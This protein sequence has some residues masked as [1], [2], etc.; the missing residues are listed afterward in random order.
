[1]SCKGPLASLGTSTPKLSF[2]RLVHS[3]QQQQKQ[4]QQQQQQQQQQ[5]ETNQHLL[6]GRTKR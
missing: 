4:K 2:I 6:I 1:M 5:H 3:D